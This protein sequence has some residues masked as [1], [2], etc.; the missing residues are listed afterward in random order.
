MRNYP[1]IFHTAQSM[2]STYLTSTVTKFYKLN[3]LESWEIRGWDQRACGDLA[4]LLNIAGES[5]R[6]EK[7][8]TYE[9]GVQRYG[10]GFQ[11]SQCYWLEETAETEGH[12]ERD[13]VQGCRA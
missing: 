9:E 1:S 6:E 7:E 5:E 10:L 2:Y 13:P 11:E 12:D 4:Q 8:G 3:F